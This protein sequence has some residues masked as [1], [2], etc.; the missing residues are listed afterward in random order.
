MAAPLRVA[1]AGTPEFAAA[2][3]DLLAETLAAQPG[4]PG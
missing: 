3:L 2:A 4:K 1:F